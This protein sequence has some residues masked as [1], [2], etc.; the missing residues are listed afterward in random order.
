GGGVGGLGT[1]RGFRAVLGV[2]LIGEEQ[3][4][5]ALTI[6][7]TQP[8]EFPPQV[9]DLMATFA[10][11]SALAMQ[12]ARL[13]HQLEITSKHKSQFLANMSHELRTPLNAILGYTE[14]I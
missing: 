4:M 1:E 3:G 8:G 11:Q 10:S 12:N 9:V 2:P 5:G 7:R 13:Y 6:A 14:L